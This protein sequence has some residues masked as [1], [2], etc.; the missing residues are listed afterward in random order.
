MPNFLKSKLVMRYL[1]LPMAMCCLSASAF[2]QQNATL[3]QMLLAMKSQDQAVREVIKQS[4][5]DLTAAQVKHI[6]KTDNKHTR[7]LKAIVDNYGWPSLSLVGEDG[8]QAAFLLVQH[9]P[10]FTFQQAMLPH[11]HRA[12]QN[13]EGITGQEV[14]LLT[15][16]ILIKKGQPQK[17]GTQADIAANTVTFLPIEDADNVDERRAQMGLPPLAEYK[18]MLEHFYAK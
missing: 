6:Q 14:A 12:Y 17:Y 1:M 9:S 2:A 18:N 4:G 5:G 13:D 16:R 8:V 7:Q 15:D 10:D 11:I 3:S